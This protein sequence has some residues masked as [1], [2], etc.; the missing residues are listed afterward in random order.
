MTKTKKHGTSQEDN[1]K[2]AKV[3]CLIKYLHPSGHMQKKWPNPMHQQWLEGMIVVRKEMQRVNRLNQMCLVVTHKDFSEELY[4]V[5]K[6]FK[7]VEEGPPEY[8]FSDDPR[9]IQRKQ[10]QRKATKGNLCQR[11]HGGLNGEDMLSWKICN[12]YA[13]LLRLTMIM[14]RSHSSMQRVT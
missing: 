4:A 12:N 13:V 8:F 5:A 10:R 9:R 1:G 7:L 2:G 14:N 11:W 6:W 3:S